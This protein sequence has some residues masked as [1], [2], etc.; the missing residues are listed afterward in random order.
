MFLELVSVAVLLLST[1]LFL[2][3][4]RNFN[5]WKARGIPGPEPSL[6]YGSAK[7]VFLKSKIY[8]VDVEEIYK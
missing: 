7:S 4:T 8:S 5:F 6:I 3:W 1:F 2:W